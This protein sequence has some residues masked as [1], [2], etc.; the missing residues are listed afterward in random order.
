[1]KFIIAKKIEMTQRFRPDGTVVPVTLVA[2]G[3]CVVAQVK[4]SE[5]DGYAAVQVG[6]GK[7]KK[8]NKP[9]AGHLKDLEN[10]EV[11]KEFRVES[12]DLKRGGK[13]DL[14]QFAI[15][16]KVEV[17]GISKGKGFQGVVKRHHFHGHPRTHGTKD[18]ERMP[19]SIGSGG[20]QRVFKGLRMGGHMGD[21]QI[22]IKNLEIIEIDKEKNILALKG[23]VPGARGA[24]LFIKSK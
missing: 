12:T 4:T 10:S 5:K 3:P 20:N 22:T 9:L 7:K 17:T 1:M 2:A 24:I 13:L 6:F 21:E 8:I 11:L 16:E 18:S 14:S 15:G 19:G 23:A